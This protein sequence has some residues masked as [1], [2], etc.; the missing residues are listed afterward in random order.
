MAVSFPSIPMQNGSCRYPGCQNSTFQNANGSYSSFCSRRHRDAAS[1]VQQSNEPQAATEV[2]PT[3][4]LCKNCQLRP[5]YSDGNRAHEFCGTRCRDAYQTSAGGATQ[6]RPAGP[7]TGTCKLR[8]CQRPVYVG[9]NGRPSEYC[10]MAHR[11]EGVQTGAELCLLYASRNSGSPAHDVDTDRRWA[12]RCGQWPKV[13]I[14]GKLSDFCSNRCKEDTFSS[15]PLILHLDKEMAAFKDVEKQFTD[16][17]KHPTTVPTVVKIWKIYS[18]KK[19][20]DDFLSYKDAVE[21]MTGLPGGNSRRRWHGTFRQC[22][23][24]DTESQVALCQDANCSLCRIIETSFSV[25]QA[26]KRFGGRFGKGI[27]ISATSSKSNDYVQ[28]RGG[29]PYKAMLL[30]DVVMG[31]TKKLTTG[32]MTLMEPPAGYDSVVGEPGADL[33]YDEAIVYRDDA[34]RPLFLI[35]YKM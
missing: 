11:A 21:R 14:N 2:G 4:G 1:S 16:K 18:R 28:E 35:I 31:K 8:G 22:T 13:I 25:A 3:V 24:G 33:N 26:S 12:T 6:A 29:S 5:V 34:I 9:P 17:W 10:S 20:T 27:Y 7:R 32:D 23:I 30:N 15:A 19:H